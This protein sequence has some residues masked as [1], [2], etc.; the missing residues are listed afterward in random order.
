M[1]F[2]ENEIRTD[3]IDVEARSIDN[4]YSKSTSKRHVWFHLDDSDE[5]AVSGRFVTPHVYIFEHDSD[6]RLSDLTE[7]VCSYR[8]EFVMAQGIVWPDELDGVVQHCD[9]CV[10]A[11]LEWIYAVSPWMDDV[12]GETLADV[13]MLMQLERVV[14]DRGEG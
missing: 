5:V 10:V 1:R 14:D 4:A 13:A 3:C 12:D 6:E 8:Q 11:D 9:D 2:T 7:C